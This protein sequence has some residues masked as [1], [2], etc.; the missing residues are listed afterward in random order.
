MHMCKKF[1]YYLTGVI[2]IIVSYVLMN[3]MQ[4]PNS[5]SFAISDILLVTWYNGLMG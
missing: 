1:V 3:V 4:E 2:I 5:N